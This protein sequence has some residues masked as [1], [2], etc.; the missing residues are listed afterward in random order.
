MLFR[1]DWSEDEWNRFF[2]FMFMCV[3]FY[4]KFG[5]IDAEQGEKYRLKKVKNQFGE[6]FLNWWEDNRN[7]ELK[8]ALK[9]NSLYSEF[10]NVYGLEKKDYSIK[11]FKKAL[12]DTAEMFGYQLVERKERQENNLLYVHILEI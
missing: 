10:L 5:I 9:F 6:D 3:N 12:K 2:N 4:L 1:S 11:R 7:L 8:S